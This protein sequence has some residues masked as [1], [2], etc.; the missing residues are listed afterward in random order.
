VLIWL[1]STTGP[2]FIG[3]AEIIGDKAIQD[4]MIEKIPEKY[5]LARI[6]F[7]GP[8]RAKFDDGQIITIRISPVSGELLILAEDRAVAQTCE[9][10]RGR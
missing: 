8:N 2:A 6:G 5:F 1:G 3:K 9:S 7:F 4:S 10:A